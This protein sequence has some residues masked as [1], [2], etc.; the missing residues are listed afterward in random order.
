[1]VQSCHKLNQILDKEIFE[2][3]LTTKV[4]RI[5]LESE[6]AQ[7]L[8]LRLHVGHHFVVDFQFEPTS[9]VGQVN[10]VPLPVVVAA[11]KRKR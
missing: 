1:M 2:K 6:Q 3:M 8:E 5:M 9:L 11:G 10:L 7:R 4:E